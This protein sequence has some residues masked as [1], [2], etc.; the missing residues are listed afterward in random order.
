MLIVY[1]P[2]GLHRVLQ[3]LVVILILGWGAAPL[4]ARVLGPAGTPTP[5]SPLN[6]TAAAANLQLHFDLNGFCPWSVQA[7]G[8]FITITPPA[9]GIGSAGVTVNFSI[10][11]NQG[12]P[13]QG[14]ITITAGSTGYVLQIFQDGN[15]TTPP[16]VPSGLAATPVSA[17]Q[18]DLTWTASTDNVAVTGYR[19]FRGGSLVGNSSTPSF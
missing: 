10:S 13:R 4:R 3:W 2:H 7:A 17:S 18:V 8:G 19:I 9:S 16:S 15:D 1:T 12:P 6:L 5:A 11:A 14:S